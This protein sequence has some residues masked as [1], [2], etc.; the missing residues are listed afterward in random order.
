MAFSQ[1]GVEA[2]CLCPLSPGL[3]ASS[4]LLSE[5][6]PSPCSGW[7][8]ALSPLHSHT[9]L[10]SGAQLG[11]TT[12]QDEWIMTSWLLLTAHL[13]EEEATGL[14]QVFPFVKVYSRP[15]L[16]QAKNMHIIICLQW[17]LSPAEK[18]P[19]EQLAVYFCEVTAKKKMSGPYSRSNRERGWGD[20]SVSKV[21]SM[22]AWGPGFYHLHV[23]KINLVW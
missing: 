5:S 23:C 1:H 10:V 16:K 8:L 2:P 14:L 13:S 12:P 20:S 9:E 22:Q 7:P 19:W 18:Q 15:L 3:C 21:L 17:I 6:H 4:I 11:L